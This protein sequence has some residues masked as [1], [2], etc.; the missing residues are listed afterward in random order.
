[1]KTT[2]PLHRWLALQFLMVASV[3]LVTV[4]ALVWLFLLPQIRHDISIN[5]Q[6]LARA[7]AG[8]ISV[9]LHGAELEL[10]A[11]ANYI[12]KLGRRKASYWFELLDA[13]AGNGDVFEAIYIAGNN[14]RV[15]TV[16]LPRFRRDQRED[17][18]GLDLSGRA[19]FSHS[20]VQ[21]KDVWSDTFLS[22]I[23]GRLAVALAI[24]ISDQTIIGE[25]TTNQLSKFISQ[26]PVESEIFTMILDHRGRIIADSQRTY[27]GQQANLNILHLIS[28][29][30]ERQ[31][32]THRFEFQGRAFIGTIVDVK[33]LGWKV[34]V[35][36]SYHDALWPITS[37]LGMIGVGLVFSLLLAFAAGWLQA[38]GFS[39]QFRRYTE[40]A[41]AITHGD[42]DRPWPESKL[43]EFSDLAGNLQNMAY[44]I[45]EREKELT[46]SEE[47]Y[48]KLFETVEVS[49]RRFKDLFNDAPVMYVITEN[50][51]GKP[52]IRDVNNMF[53]QI[54][55]YI[56]ED[57]LGTPLAKYYTED[58]KK[59]MLEKGGYLRG[60]K[61]EFTPEERGLLTHDGQVVY[62]LL[63]TRPEADSNNN[64]IGTRAMFL[65]ITAL[66]HAEQETRR[67]ES[68]L[69]QTQK[70]ES[71]GTLAGGVA[72]EINNPINGIMNYA[73]LI[74][75]GIPEDSSERG[76]AQEILNETQ[77]VSQIVR[78]LLTFARHEKQ[79]H[80]PANFSDIVTSVLSLI[81][82]V[83]RRDQIDLHVEIPEDLPKIKCRSQQIQQVLMNLMTN[84]RDALNERY[85]GYD[86]E[87][88]LRIYTERIMKQDKK[89]IRT[90]VED[91]GAGIPAAIRDRIF[92]PFFTTKPKEKGTGLGLS[93]SYGII[94]DHGGDLI[95]ESE[96][97]QYTR[98][99]MDL[100][101]D[102]GWKI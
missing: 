58:S 100:P 38:S 96:P 21:K 31:F 72:H 8:Q 90:T 81:Q 63:H 64:V 32:V 3:P 78:N 54:L 99:H 48:R 60:L 51:N 11:V 5:H 67:L 12:K 73:Q 14:D 24:P 80:S 52:Y 40:Q 74:L 47:K 30:Q 92:D 19:F 23:S 76:F 101:V 87:K 41:N 53:S 94:K 18:L 9:H 55:G 61:G 34:L 98:F 70:M 45:R 35:A 59:Q 39:R 26:L 83:V 44:A 7:V 27:G 10:S 42:Y 88:R 69:S 36:Q 77:R 84:A 43:R 102:N 93:I 62:T 49:E 6:I 66:K 86:P 71:I 13:H 82:T 22:T 33:R 68:A 25:I 1:M 57:V 85:P 16:G 56:R 15:Y 50:R 4:A 29:E 91:S 17:L 97:E 75:D 79:S 20:R 37:T 2:R 28:T 95:V 65:D 46:A 89:F